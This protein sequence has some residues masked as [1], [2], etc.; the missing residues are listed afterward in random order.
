MDAL[1]VESNACVEDGLQIRP[2]WT[3]GSAPPEAN[4]AVRHRQKAGTAGRHRRPVVAA[5]VVHRARP[6]G[7]VAHNPRGLTW[8]KPA[9]IASDSGTKRKTTHATAPPTPSERRVRRLTGYTQPPPSVLSTSAPAGVTPS[10][11]ITNSQ[12]CAQPAIRAQIPGR[13][14]PK[15]PATFHGSVG[16]RARALTTPFGNLR[17]IGQQV[18]PTGPHSFRTSRSS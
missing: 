15:I 12:T 2:A 17:E 3:S 8:R 10:T 5:T 16:V 6:N 9:G 1:L 4:S 13:C 11:F 7:C 14:N 18:F